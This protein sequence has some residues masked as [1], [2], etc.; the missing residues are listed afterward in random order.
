MITVYPPC[1]NHKQ[2]EMYAHACYYRYI[3]KHF[4]ILDFRQAPRYNANYARSPK[5]QTNAPL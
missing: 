5:P 1:Q 2:K 4:F 3:L